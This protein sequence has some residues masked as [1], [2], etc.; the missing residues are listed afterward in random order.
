MAIRWGMGLPVTTQVPG[1][2][3]D[4]EADALIEDVVAIVQAADRAGA[5]HVTTSHHVAVPSERVDAYASTHGSHFWDPPT[6]FA[7][8]AAHTERVRFLPYCYVIGLAHPLELAK[9]FGTVDHVSNGRLILGFGVGNYAPEFHTLGREFDDRGAAADDALRALRVTMGR[10]LVSYTGT[11]YHYEDYV[12]SP[13]SVQAPVPMWIA[14]HSRRALRRA[15]ELGDGWM[16]TPAAYGGPDDDTV[17]AMLAEHDVSAAFEV[18]LSPGGPLDPINEPDTVAAHLIA[19]ESSPATI[20]NVRFRHRSRGELSEQ[21]EAFA[22]VA[23]T[24]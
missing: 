13:H 23:A 21:I 15:V 8:L 22:R 2:S 17:R 9:Q 24:V 20:I 1:G 16:P 10:R 12:V 14:G 7:F 5:H 4:W 19:A 6:A 3:A 11:H 18:L